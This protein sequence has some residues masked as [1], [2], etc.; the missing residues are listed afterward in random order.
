MNRAS[1][2]VEDGVIGQVGKINGPAD[3][4]IDGSG[5]I[6]LPGLINAHTHLSMTLFRGYA[7]DM[8]LQDW[9]QKKIWPLE[10]KLTN[11][12]CYF[13]ALLGA[14][15]MIRSGTTSFVD[16][17][18]HMEDVARA[19]A[20][21]GLRGFLSYG[22][23]DLFDAA[24]SS[25]SEPTFRSSMITLDVWKIQESDSSLDHMHLTP[26]QLKCFNGRKNLLRRTTQ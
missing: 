6:A 3:K 4:E 12:D 26:V 19:V 25:R 8:Q 17:Y 14:L 21:S 7:D 2:L 16:M 15:E 11:E 10:A 9:L 22:T 24:K 5:K 20:E 1:I 18:F 23:I 13:G